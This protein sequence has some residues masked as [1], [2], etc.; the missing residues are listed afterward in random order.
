MSSKTKTAASKTVPAPKRKDRE[1]DGEA[2]GD[3]LSA[4]ALKKAFLAKYATPTASTRTIRTGGS[5]LPCVSVEGIVT[6]TKIIQVKGKKP[7]STVPKIEVSVDVTKVRANTARDVIVSGVGGFDWLLP[8]LKPPTAAAARDAADDSPEGGGDKKT[9]KAGDPAP[10]RS[11]A[12]L[13]NHKTI[14][15]GNF[16]KVSF[17]MTAGGKDGAQIDKKG[18]DLIVPGMPVEVLGVTA[19]LS[20]DGQYLWLNATSCNPKLDGIVP[21]SAPQVI[22][23][24]LSKPDVMKSAALRLSQTMRGFFGTVAG[25]PELE[26]QAQPFREMWGSVRDG[27]IAALEARATEIRADL[28]T[29]GEQ[30]ACV[31]DDDSAKLKQKNPADLAFGTPIFPPAMPVT[32]DRP[33]F[34][35]PIVHELAGMDLPGMH[36]MVATLVGLAGDPDKLP[37]TFVA[38]DVVETELQGALL[39]AKLRLTFVGDKTKAL[40]A[41][42]AGKDPLIN[43]GRFAALGIKFNM[44][45]LPASTGVLIAPKASDLCP[46]LLKYGKWSAIAPVTPRETTDEGVACCFVNGYAI[47]MVPS[48]Q[49]VGVLVDEAFVK[50]VLCGGTEQHAYEEDPDAQWLTDKDGVRLTM[51]LPNIKS[52]GYQEITGSTFKFAQARMPADKPNRKYHVWWADAPSMILDDTE[53]LGDPAKGQ[54]AVAQGA[55]EL[56]LSLNDFISQRCAIYCVA[57]A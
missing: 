48:V 46:A 14:W 2:D 26:E 45:D 22:A 30:L 37:D 12:L 55:Q 50:K 5:A 38:P 44:R 18:M 8:T 54:D 47:D 53:L 51:P 31:L 13:P 19:A 28:G 43:S 25:T 17:Y 9:D 57:V 52:H 6:R 10:V 20:D 11:L 4:G 33:A 16:P 35:A 41:I 15:L 29:D 27:T 21:G 39:F 49:N 40:A 34:T 1:A 3:A 36:Q 56:G 32:P 42:K 7:G 23:D 24:T